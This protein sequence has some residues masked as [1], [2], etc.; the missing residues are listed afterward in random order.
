MKEIVNFKNIYLS[1]W[2]P[3]LSFSVYNCVQLAVGCQ[4]FIAS[5]S[6]HFSIYVL[7]KIK[8]KMSNKIIFGHLCVFVIGVG[9]PCFQAL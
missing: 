4:I 6:I 3:M 2:Q 5:V 7:I 8:K 9:L 1:P